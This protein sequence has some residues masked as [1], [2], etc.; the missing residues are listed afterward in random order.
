MPEI[1]ASD[2]IPE[3]IIECLWKNKEQ[4]IDNDVLVVTQK[5]V[6]KSENRVVNLK[7]ITPDRKAL[8]LSKSLN[9]DARLIQLILNESKSIIKLDEKRGIIITENNNGHISANSG[10]DFSNIK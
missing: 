7:S 10:I 9:K 6:S 8:N 4:L 1:K 2:N 3:L 5:I